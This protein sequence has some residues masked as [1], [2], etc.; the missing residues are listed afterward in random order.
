MSSPEAVWSTSDQRNTGMERQMYSFSN[1]QK[2]VDVRVCMA[3]RVC[4]RC[5]NSFEGRSTAPKRRG[6]RDK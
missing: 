6:K 3:R 5:K 1:L 2:E 4:E